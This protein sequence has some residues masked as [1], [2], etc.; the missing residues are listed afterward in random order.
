MGVGRRA[1]TQEA[2]RLSLSSHQSRGARRPLTIAPP[3]PTFNR[4][5]L[6]QRPLLEVRLSPLLGLCSAEQ[7]SQGARHRAVTSH[8]QTVWV[9]L[10]TPSTGAHELA[11]TGRHRTQPNRPASIDERDSLPSIDLSLPIKWKVIGMFGDQDLC[12]RTFGRAIRPRLACGVRPCRRPTSETTTP[13]ARV[14]S[15]TRALKSQ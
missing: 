9:R 14:T 3:P 4:D 8:R 11:A 13:A 1:P 12:R 5:D 6:S 7:T 2:R 15:T 10:L